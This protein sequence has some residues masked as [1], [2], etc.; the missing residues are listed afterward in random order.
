MPPLTE[1][2][3]LQPECPGEAVRLPLTPVELLQSQPPTNECTLKASLSLHEASRGYSCL[4][5]L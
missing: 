1:A 5:L 3:R 2:M 4:H